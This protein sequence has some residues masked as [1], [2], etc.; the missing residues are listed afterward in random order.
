MTL[1]ERAAVFK[2]LGHPARL[3]IVDRLAAGECCVCELLEPTEY[4]G[5]SGP[6]VSQH[7]LVLKSA[8][9]IADEKRGKRIFYRLAMP[10]VSGISLCV[11]ARKSTKT[12][13]RV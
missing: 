5:L 3:A 7:L 1:R 10:C 2:A 4:S 12:H 13:Y 9:V 8:G 11:Q 6:T